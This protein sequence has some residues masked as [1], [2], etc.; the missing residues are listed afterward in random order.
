MGSGEEGRGWG[1][2]GEHHFTYEN[3]NTMLFIIGNIIHYRK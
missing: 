3:V 2:G 1:K